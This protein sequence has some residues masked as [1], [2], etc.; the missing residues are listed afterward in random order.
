MPPS[1]RLRILKAYVPRCVDELG[2]ENSMRAG[3]FLGRARQESLNESA[4]ARPQSVKES[5]CRV[6]RSAKP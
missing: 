6:R 3:D 5:F 2:E 4:E 1:C